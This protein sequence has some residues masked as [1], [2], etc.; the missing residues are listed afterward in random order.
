[1]S[2][3]C[4]V[5]ERPAIVATD[6]ALEIHIKIHIDVSHAKVDVIVIYSAG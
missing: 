4:Q 5:K 1:M 2:L 3:V 6:V